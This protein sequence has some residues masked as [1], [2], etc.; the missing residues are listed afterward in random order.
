M[1]PAIQTEIGKIPLPI[2]R[3]F[4]LARERYN[5]YLRRGEGKPWP[6]TKDKILQDNRFCNVFRELDKTT[7]WFRKNVR[8]RTKAKHIF[9]ATVVFRWFNRI[10]TGEAIFNQTDIGFGGRTAFEEFVKTGDAEVLVHTVRRYC[11][12][13][14]YV[15]GA[16]MVPSPRGEG[17]D[18]L[19]GIA[20]CCADFWGAGY[21][22]LDGGEMGWRE[23]TECLMTNESWSKVDKGATIGLEATWTWLKQHPYQGPF[24]AY[25]VVSDLRHTPLL[26]DVPD[27]MTW[28]N[29][30]PGAIRGLE[31]IWDGDTSFKNVELMQAILGKSRLKK[32]WP[33]E[34][35]AWEMREVEHWLCEFDKYERVRL[36]QGRMKNVYRRS[37]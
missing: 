37:V 14:P 22:L 30:G 18:K 31:R 6:W 9:I 23:V 15:T 27:I 3:Y 16:Y 1:N 5:I 19:E 29:A 21:P 33:K 2:D 4:A 12:P 25:E 32:N 8:E 35:P 17:L 24:N 7:I 10:T 28:A 13:G 26:S 20:K 11:A 36:G 34:W